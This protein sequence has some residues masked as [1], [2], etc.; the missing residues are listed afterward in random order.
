MVGVLEIKAG[1]D[2][3][4]AALQIVQ[5]ISSLKTE[6]AI[7]AAV[8][9]IQ[10]LT[11][12]AQRAL[13]ASLD[14]IDELEKEIV[15]LKDWSAEKEGYEL[16]DAGQGSLAYRLK[17]GVEPPRPAHWICP[18]CYEKGEKSILKHEHLAIGR[19]DTLVC[20]PCGFDIVVRGVRHSQ[21]P[22]SVGRRRG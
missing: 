11:L 17:E 18:H 22:A 7:N 6:T 2:S 16:A 20:H 14:Q 8:I 21:Q 15:H 12:D 10:R 5:G 1:Y 4:K 13:S 3:A 9:D 19:A